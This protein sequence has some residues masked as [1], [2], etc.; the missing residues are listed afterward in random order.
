M[1][2]IIAV[3]PARYES[4]RFPGK[5]LAMINGKTMV[6]RVY[7][8]V[9]AVDQIA[10]VMVATDDE[11][12]RKEVERFGG[13][14]VMTGECSCGT[15]RVYEAIKKEK[16]DIV[17]NVQ[18]DE[19]LIKAEMI[20]DLTDA[21]LD[22]N[23]V[24]ATLRRRITDENE[25]QDPNIVKV[26]VNNAGNAIYFSRYPIPYNRDNIKNVN[27]YKHIGIYGYTKDFLEKYVAFPGTAL[28][29]SENLEQL[30]VLE[31]GYPIRVVETKYDSTG[32]DIPEHIGLI[33]ELL[34]NEQ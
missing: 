1:K 12:I 14:A 10:K 2:R 16:C 32:V 18:G 29:R 8:R 3:I 25:I 15:E 23:V 26:V 5:P 6:S 11:R 34:T 31:H 7:E 27:Y 17:L 21:F 9:E 33:E 4:S 24:M 20:R 30:R 28:E 22:E 19:P 13:C